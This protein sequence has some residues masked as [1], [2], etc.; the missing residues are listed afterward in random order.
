MLVKLIAVLFILIGIAG[1][2]LPIV[3]GILMIVIGILLLYRDRHEEI[4]KHINEKAPLWLINFYN[5]FLHKII[6]P[7]H[8]I[9]VDW[10]WVRKEVIRTEKISNDNKAPAAGIRAVLDECMRKARS[11]TITKYT[12]VEKK[13]NNIG[14]GFIEIEGGIKFSTERISSYIRGATHLVLFIATIG[15]GIEKEAGLLTKGAEPLKGYLLDRIS[16]FAVESLA[17]KMENRIR[18]DYLLNKKSVSCRFSPGYC[19]WAIEEQFEM[20]RVID[21]SKI[22]IRLTESCMMDPKKSISAIV[23]VADEGVFKGAVSS[24][25]MCDIKDCAYRRDTAG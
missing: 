10:D 5:N 23:A 3:P 9:G 14:S 6:L 13:I 12:S 24:C 17:E 15:D 19:D 2:V 4:S 16:S 11:L 7:P 21:F 25:D 18:K 1:L 8:Y 22:G 20:D